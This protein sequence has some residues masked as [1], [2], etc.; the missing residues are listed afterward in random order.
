MQTD[1]YFQL[2]NPLVFALFAIG[3]LCVHAIR[4]SK[5]A[6]A[7]AASYGFGMSAFL[8]DLMFQSSEFIPLRV[9]IAGL[10]ALTAAMLSIGFCLHFRRRAPWRLL[11]VMT[12]AHLAI[13]SVLYVQDFVWWRSF[14]ANTGC[15]FIFLVGLMAFPR[16]GL[17]LPDKVLFGVHAA[18]CLQCFTRPALVAFLTAGP[19]TADNHSEDLFLVT[20]HLAVGASA[21]LTGMLILVVLIRE[22]VIDLQSHSMTDE[23]TGVC[24]RRGFDARVTHWANTSRQPEIGIILADLDRFK[25]VNDTYGHN[26]GDDILIAFGDLLRTYSGPGRVAARLGGEEFVLAFSN[27]PMSEVKGI[28]ESLRRMMAAKTFHFGSET[29]TVTASFGVAQVHQNENLRNALARADNALY[30]AKREGRNR[31]C[32]QADLA[33]DRLSQT[34]AALKPEA[35]QRSKQ[36]AS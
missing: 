33:V 15:G 25:R 18:S 3:F 14:A 29:V 21:V 13:Y 6:C 9:L 34:K 5:A 17:A 11:L 16:R 26:A 24:N 31:V 23:L 7:F 19:L 30:L 2:L 10:Y 8:L 36:K 22:V 32:C 4:P 27:M 35:S 1:L 12:L 28:A 20:L